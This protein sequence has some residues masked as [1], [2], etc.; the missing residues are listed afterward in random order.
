[1]LRNHKSYPV[2]PVCPDVVDVDSSKHDVVEPVVYRGGPMTS[3][4]RNLIY[5]Q[6]NLP[7]I[8]RRSIFTEEEKEQRKVLIMYDI[9]IY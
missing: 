7:G 6:Y 2:D 5:A 4:K 3:K 1:M 9:C 8:G